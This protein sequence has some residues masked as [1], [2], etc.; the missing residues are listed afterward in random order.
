MGDGR[1][2]TGP[3]KI[4][5]YGELNEYELT[6][7]LRVDVDNT[8]TKRLTDRMEKAVEKHK[9]ELVANEDL[10]DRML[11]YPI[12][13]EGKGHYHLLR[14]FGEGDLIAELEGYL[15]I[16]P[17]V[18]RFLSVRIAKNIDP[19]QRKKELSKKELSEAAL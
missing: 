1:G 18:L 14:L 13:K 16:A 10:G 19:Q 3:T 4:S 12:H 2:V 5:H 17:E 11:A 15:R 8:K 7:I 9:A 6:Y